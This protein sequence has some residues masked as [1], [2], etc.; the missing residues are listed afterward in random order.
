VLCAVFGVTVLAGVVTGS[1]AAWAMAGL[2]GVALAGYVALVVHLRRMALERELKL[3][4][5]DPDAGRP[6]RE[7]GPPSYISGRYAHPSSQQA[8]AH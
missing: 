7:Y 8:V 2:D 1:T 6:A 3:R 4:Y 5:L